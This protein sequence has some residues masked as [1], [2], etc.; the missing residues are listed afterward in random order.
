MFR[1]WQPK[2][3]ANV[4]LGAVVVLAI[5]A[6]AVLYYDLGFYTPSVV[7]RGQVSV[8]S[9]SDPTKRMTAA[10]RLIAVR[11]QF[12]QVEYPP[13]VWSDCHQSCADALRKA[14]FNE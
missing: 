3:A 7:Q 9:R 11:R 12:W 1:M 8:T 6:G 14:A 2:S 4:L 5:G 13:G 10:T